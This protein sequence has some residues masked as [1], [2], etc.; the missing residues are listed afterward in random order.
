MWDLQQIN[1]LVRTSDSSDVKWEIF[2]YWSIVDLQCVN[3]CCTAKWLS[4]TYMYILFFNILFHYGLSQD[5]E[6]SSLCS[7]VGPCCLSILNVIVCIYQPQTPTPSLSLLTSPLANTSLF[8]MSLS[9]FLFCREVHLCRIL[10][11][12]Y[13]WYNM[14]FVF[15]CLTYF[16]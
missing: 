5:N 15:L 8:S 4:Y 2:L 16:T 1:Y 13:K 11:S 6:Y 3:F 7:T 14:V 10:D 12:T 9:L